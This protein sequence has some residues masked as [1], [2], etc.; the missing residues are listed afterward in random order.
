MLFIS[1]SNATNR[2]FM[3]PTRVYLLGIDKKNVH[4]PKMFKILN[5]S[6]EPRMRF[7]FFSQ[8]FCM[9]QRHGAR[10][11]PHKDE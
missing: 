7:I 11:N 6:N 8:I 5:A 10:E 2:I 3:R 1:L 9:V 4:K